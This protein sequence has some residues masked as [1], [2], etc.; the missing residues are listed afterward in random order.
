MV[1]TPPMWWRRVRTLPSCHFA[2]EVLRIRTT[3]GRCARGRSV[4]WPSRTGNALSGYCGL[5]QLT[6]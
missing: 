3:L 2:V 1:E 5:G 4:E 6:R